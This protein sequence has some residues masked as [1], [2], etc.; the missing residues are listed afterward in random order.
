MGD[1]FTTLSFQYAKEVFWSVRELNLTVS[2]CA[3]EFK[4]DAYTL[5]TIN[6]G[7]S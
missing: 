6:R 2:D 5:V 4:V 1:V 7:F 3:T